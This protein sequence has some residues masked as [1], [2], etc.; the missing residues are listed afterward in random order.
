MDGVVQVLIR[1]GYAV[2]FGAVLA[3]QIGLP[4][5][6]E[7]VLLAAG[8]MVGSGHLHPVVV[9]ALATVA[10]LI[11]DTIWYWIGR[12]GGPRVLGWLCRV[13]LE[14]DSCV[15]RTEHMFATRGA[16]ALVVAKFVPG[17]ATIGPPLAGVLRLSLRTFLVFSTLGAMC[18]AGAFLAVGWLFSSQLE[19]AAAYVVRLGSWA[20]VLVVLALSAYILWKY[21]GRQRFL[22]RIRMAKITP[23]ELKARLDGGEQMLVVDVRDRLAFE[24]EPSIIPGA[25]HLS[26]EELEA[27]HGEIPRE[28]EI[29]L[30]CT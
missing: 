1:Y 20:I 27:R 25:L 21:I 7:P 22:R 2:V 23:E 29:V 28:R 11:G 14:P 26:V 9:L 18:W 19:L 3:E 10:S 4:L 30:Y 8:G 17:L 5:P 13:S 6:S 12:A 24:A 15:R 16:R